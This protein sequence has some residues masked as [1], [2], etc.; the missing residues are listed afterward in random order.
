MH[1]HQCLYMC[2]ENRFEIVEDSFAYAH[3]IALCADSVHCS[4]CQFGVGGVR[5]PFSTHAWSCGGLESFQTCLEGFRKTTP[6]HVWLVCFQWLE[7]V[8]VCVR[9]GSFD[10]LLN[11]RVRIHAYKH[12]HTHTGIQTLH[13]QLNCANVCPHNFA[14]N[15]PEISTLSRNFTQKNPEISA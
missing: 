5:P 3:V 11:N 10:C 15:F 4:T 8:G 13:K 1:S 6:P 12:M 9:T 2:R 7:S 14:H